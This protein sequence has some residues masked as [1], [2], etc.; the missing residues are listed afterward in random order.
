MRRKGSLVNILIW[1]LV[2]V[3]AA[4]LI[5]TWWFRDDKPALGKM[6]PGRVTFKQVIRDAMCDCAEIF[7]ALVAPPWVRSFVR[8]AWH[9][10]GPKL[11][12]GSTWAAL[13]TNGVIA[14]QA[15]MA[16]P[17]GQAFMAAHPQFYMM[18]AVVALFATRQQG[19]PTR[20]PGEPAGGPGAEV[21]R[22]N[23]Q[24][25]AQAFARNP[26]TGLR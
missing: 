13:V 12:N 17:D 5:A 4:W 26:A 18:G 14:W 2:F 10:A 9:W 23:M 1:T 11:T 25:D 7:M 21:E 3:V 16:G 22:Q 20:I 24:Q 19:A 6:E 8:R 15:F